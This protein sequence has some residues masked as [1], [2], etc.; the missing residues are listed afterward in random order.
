MKKLY[1]LLVPSTRPNPPGKNKL[2]TLKYHRL[3]DSKVRAIA[4]GL[5]ILTPAKGSWL[6]PEGDLYLDRV[7]PVQIM[8][9]EEQIQEIVDFTAKHYFQIAIFYYVVSSDVRIKHFKLERMKNGE[10][11]H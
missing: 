6:S 10:A 3:W 4:G 1:C 5:T 9:T 7:I 11:M 8:C 2:F